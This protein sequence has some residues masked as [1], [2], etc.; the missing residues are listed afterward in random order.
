[1]YSAIENNLGTN[2]S[3]HHKCEIIKLAQSIKI[4]VVET[5]ETG[6]GLIDE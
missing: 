1:M 5:K 4:P 3:E 2:R 6:Y